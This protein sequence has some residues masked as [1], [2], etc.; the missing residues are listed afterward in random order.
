M[1]LSELSQITVGQSILGVF[2]GI[3]FSQLSL[4]A[5]K[6]ESGTGV[7]TDLSRSAYVAAA[8]VA[9]LVL[10][11]FFWLLQRSVKSLSELTTTQKLST[12]V[13]AA[14]IWLGITTL[15][16]FGVITVIV[17]G[18]PLGAYAWFEGIS[19]HQALLSA[20][21][22]PVWLAFVIGLAVISIARQLDGG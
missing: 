22:I 21:V 18:L 11:A 12:E 5:V 7:S 16:S 1:P 13:R 19:F 10:T 15:F 4:A 6:A 8:T 14:T 2:W 17:A 3:W 20:V 9:V